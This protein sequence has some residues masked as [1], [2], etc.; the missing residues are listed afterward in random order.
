MQFSEEKAR[1]ILNDA[2]RFVAR[3]EEY[4]RSVKAI[5]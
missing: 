4:L 2:E 3:L 1:Q 5:E